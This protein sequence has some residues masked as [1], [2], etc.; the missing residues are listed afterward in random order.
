MNYDIIHVPYH[1]FSSS[2][3]ER[4]KSQ[5]NVVPEQRHEASKNASRAP[6]ASGA[7][8][9][10]TTGEEEGLQTPRQG[11]QPEAGDSETAAQEGA[12]Q[13]PGRVLLSH[14]QR[15]DGGRGAQGEGEGVPADGG[16]GGP[17]ADPGS[18]V[19]CQPAHLRAQQDREASGSV[20]CIRIR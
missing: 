18:Q 17:D 11:F 12:E 1:F 19:Y 5:Q 7:E 14:D 10:G 13:E 9:S 15:Q 8:Q 20:L 6:P 3:R 16:A 4:E 2:F